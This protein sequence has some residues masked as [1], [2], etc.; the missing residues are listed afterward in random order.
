MADEISFLHEPCG[1]DAQEN[2]KTVIEFGDK[3]KER[4]KNKTY[5]IWQNVQ[6]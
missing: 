6:K 1:S 2:S 3:E 5:E 4:N